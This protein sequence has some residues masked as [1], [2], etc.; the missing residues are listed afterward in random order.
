MTA[1][2]T[3]LEPLLEKFERCRKAGSV[4][5]VMFEAHKLRSAAGQM[6]AKRLE[7]ACVAI[8][9]YDQS[10]GRAKPDV[11]DEELGALADYLVWE[12]IRV[13]RRLRKL[14]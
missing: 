9:K 6:G 4:S 14:L 2:R 8:G 7:A 13:Q 1:F 11:F 5:G 12:T 10:G 3:S